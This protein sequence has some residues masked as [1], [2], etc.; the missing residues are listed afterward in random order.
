M[1]YQVAK[2]GEFRKNVS[3]MNLKTNDFYVL[4]IS[5][6]ILILILIFLVFID[7]IY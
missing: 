1:G 4:T 7:L 5:V 6:L 2:R 3:M